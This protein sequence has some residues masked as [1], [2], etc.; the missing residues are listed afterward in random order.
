MSEKLIGYNGKIAYVNLT[1]EK[2]DVKELDPHL[3]DDIQ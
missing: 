3:Q 1:E 2:V